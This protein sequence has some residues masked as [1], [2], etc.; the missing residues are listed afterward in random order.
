MTGFI[1]IVYLCGAE[2]LRVNS[3]LE[4]ATHFPPS[5]DGEEL[6]EFFS[7]YDLDDV[8]TDC[9]EEAVQCDGKCLQ[10]GLDHD[11]HDQDTA[12]GHRDAVLR[13]PYVAIY[14]DELISPDKLREWWEPIEARA[15]SVFDG[16][17]LKHSRWWLDE[18]GLVHEA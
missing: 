16:K 2:Y 7:A 11:L 15:L 12:P 5:I 10:D 8:W 18:R 14:A 4:I 17:L 1:K 13:T 6:N 3:G 9:L